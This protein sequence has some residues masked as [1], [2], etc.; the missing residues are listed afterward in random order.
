M[1]KIIAILLAFTLT[2]T[3]AQK[4]ELNKGVYKISLKSKADTTLVGVK[5]SGILIGKKTKII[6][7]GVDV[8]N[9][10]RNGID[11]TF[12]VFNT[13][14]PKKLDYSESRTIELDDN[15]E[16]TFIMYF[17]TQDAS[18]QGKTKLKFTVKQND[19]LVGVSKE[20]DIEIVGYSK[21]EFIEIGPIEKKN[22]S[23]I[24]L[25]KKNNVQLY[26]EKKEKLT[27][28]KEDA[29]RGKIDETTKVEKG[30]TVNLHKL[31]AYIKD[32]KYTLDLYTVENQIYSNNVM[33]IVE[34][35]I[36]KNFR[37]IK[38][39]NEDG[40]WINLFE[41]VSINGISKIFELP[42]KTRK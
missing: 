33:L 41:I 27:N 36:I 35:G 28:K 23:E 8:G 31:M 9:Y 15:R 25:I 22:T 4:I 3:F 26:M 7:E 20:V 30:K 12:K 16:S 11:Y 10:M 14:D 37:K 17:E 19:S 32:S 5:V 39:Q 13:S 21:K 1:I 18:F 6:I 2:H 34:N 29:D 42:D 38:L 24:E 40:T